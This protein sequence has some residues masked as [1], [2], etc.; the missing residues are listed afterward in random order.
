MFSNILATS[1]LLGKPSKLFRGKTFEL[2]PGGGGGRSSHFYCR[3]ILKACLS[4]KR[5]QAKQNEITEQFSILAKAVVN[6]HFPGHK[7]TDKYCQE[8]CNP[9]EE[10][11]KLGITKQ[12][13]PACEQAFKWLNSFKN[14]KTMNE[15]RF[16]M[17]LLYMID[18]HNLHI[19]NRV[20]L[21]A[22]P[23][24]EK[25]DDFIKKSFEKPIPIVESGASNQIDEVDEN[26]DDDLE[27]MLLD[28]KSKMTFED[29]VEEKFEDCFKSD[30]NGELI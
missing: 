21:A 18:L 20:Y 17:F 15:A 9:N 28:M 24:N 30:S 23:L 27:D 6:F 14:L 2:F 13:T 4:E 8:N 22:N 19:E 1:S 16:K 11:K 25:R 29:S 26:V 10:L 5:K 3:I 7:K 12:N